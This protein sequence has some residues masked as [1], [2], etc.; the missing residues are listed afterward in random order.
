M[1]SPDGSNTSDD[2][3]IALL[4]SEEFA[5]SLPSR[6]ILFMEGET[7]HGIH[8]ISKGHV[9]LSI[10]SCE[11]RVLILKVTEPGEILG[12]HNCVTGEPY[13][14]TAQTIQASRI[15]VV[16]RD[17]LMRVL[18]HSQE[19]C[20]SALENLGRSCHMA[21]KQMG[22]LN[23]PH[24]VR[25]KLARFLLSLSAEPTCPE[26]DCHDAAGKVV[27]LTHDEIAQALGTS[28]E[29]VSRALASFRKTHLAN[30]TR[31]ILLVQD[32]LELEKIAGMGTPRSAPAVSMGYGEKHSP[33]S[34][35]SSRPLSAHRPASQRYGTRLS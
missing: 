2:S 31:S 12:L 13:E 23:L 21:Y 35:A 28:R 20:L 33:V 3:L 17:D 8:I 26:E 18:L 6:A 30:L 27:D 7:A 10:S 15:S 29:T 24:S 14:M 11:G 32:R 1:S 4:R 5:F 34:A 25:E 9:K 16:K 19:A 22:S